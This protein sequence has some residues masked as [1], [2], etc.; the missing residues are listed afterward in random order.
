[1][2]DGA[3]PVFRPWSDGFDRSDQV[4]AA[5]IATRTATFPALGI[6]SILE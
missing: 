6:L 1:M 2:S 3:T 4:D 5:V